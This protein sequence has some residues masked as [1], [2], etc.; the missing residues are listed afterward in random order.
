MNFLNYFKAGFQVVKELRKQQKFNQGFLVDYLSEL[1]NK[2]QGNFSEEQ[3]FKINQYYGLLIG[4][5]LCGSYK[6]LYGQAFSVEER[7]RATLFGILTPLGDDLFDVHHLPIEKISALTFEPEQYQAKLFAENVVKEIQ[8]ALLHEV[9]HKE[10]YIKASKDVLD[11]QVATTAQT[12][13]EIEKNHLLEIT[14]RKGAV[15]VIIYH[16]ILSTAA[17]EQMLKVLEEVGGLYQLGNDLF[18]VYKD[19]RDGIYTIPNT[20]KDFKELKTVFVSKVKYMNELIN[21]LP[22]SNNR[23]EKFKIIMNSI[24]ARSMVAIDEWIAFQKKY[25]ANVNLKSFERKV[26]IIDMERPSLFIKW[27]Y[28]MWKLPRLI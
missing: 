28:Y 24:N 18:D 7:K 20:C 27:L 17:A 16:Q 8:S 15:S 23:K 11:L 25:G 5:I 1:E 26:L 21:A 22:Y 12:S 2:Y 19:T 3:L 14:Y 10:A 9:P 6:M 13:P 4:P